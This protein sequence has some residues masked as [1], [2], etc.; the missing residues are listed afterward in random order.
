MQ[1]NWKLLILM[2]SCEGLKYKL[3]DLCDWRTG[4]SWSYPPHNLATIIKIIIL[5]YTTIFTH[6]HI[7]CT[8]IHSS[9]KGYISRV[10]GMYVYVLQCTKTLQHDCNVYNRF[11]GMR[12]SEPNSNIHRKW[13]SGPCMK[14][15]SE[16]PHCSTLLQF[17]TVVHV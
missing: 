2:S 5:K 10:K 6:I 7:L 4:L 14:N 1:A 16:K 11:V 17:G 13:Y 15:R 3:T 9:P 8:Y 12:L